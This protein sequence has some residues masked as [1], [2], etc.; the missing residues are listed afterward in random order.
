[1]DIFGN[2]PKL[3]RREEKTSE[4][5]EVDFSYTDV[6]L[7]GITKI[8][9]KEQAFFIFGSKIIV[10]LVFC[11][12][13][14]RLFLLQVISGES[15]QKLAEGNRIRPRVIEAQRG[16]ILD[17][18]GT[19]LTRNK[20][21]YTV[22]LYPCDLPK[23]KTEREVVYQKISEVLSINIE[24][25]R[26]DAEKDG[27]FSLDYISL[28]ENISHD[29]SL[30]LKKKLN[31]VAGVS[32]INK[33][34]REYAILPGISHIL[35]YVS[36]ISREDIGKNDDYYL[37]DRIGRTG[38]EAFYESDLKGKHG[39]EQ[40]EVDSQG[41]IIRIL[42]QEGRREPIAGNDLT[43]YLDR[44]L[45]SKTAEALKIGM[46][47]AKINTG[48]DITSGVAIVMN[49]N[50]GGI[51]SM[52]SLPDFDN[53]IF[54]GKVDTEKYKALSEDKTF[55]MF[56]RAIKGT[57]PP[58]SI[59]KIVMAAAGL[60]EKVIN[61]NTSFDTPAEI[62]IGDYIFP[63]WKDHG[64][65]NVERAIAESNNIFF[66]A[67]G[68]GFDKIKG[69][70]IDGIKKYW[71]IFGLGRE[72]GIDLPGEAS[73][74]L[75]D[76]EWKEKVK[77]ESWYLGDTYHVSIGQGD[78]LITPMQM[79]RATATIANGGKL[80][81]PQIVKKITD[82]DGNVIKEFGARV[83]SEV[84]IEPEIIRT[85]QRGMRAAVTGGSARV[86]SDLPIAVAGKT[87]T[88]QFFNN[89]K[90]HAWFECYA[91]YDNPEIAVIVMVEGGGGGNEISA[92]I[93]K[94]ILSYYFSSH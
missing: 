22:A 84:S 27:L 69:I 64:N 80:L 53:N 7:E 72:T 13:F 82:H 71:K 14:F 59:I 41:N 9:S 25:V 11:V 76:P 68:G 34:D 55:P 46:E 65:T 52:V 45:Q 90:T 50:N 16:A 79:L 89:Q 10:V 38:L 91:P 70:G 3:F 54:S 62:S 18:D 88:A 93:A 12:L 51:L 75:P 40:I 61:T 33:S 86:L 36:R 77:K 85:V 8:E 15:N 47:A 29:D 1:M 31:G 17:S 81:S 37:T 4:T 49:V 73:G 92:P 67:I 2:F 48:Q 83:E 23:K 35:G 42:V 63:D 94:E 32:I 74:L 57:Y 5:E 28:L 19:W 78:L 56:N 20:P 24:D 6:T 43:L 87:G 60:S 26:K 66:Y 58:G 44:D 21:N 30:L 39:V